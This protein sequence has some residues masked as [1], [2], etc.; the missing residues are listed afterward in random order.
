MEDILKIEERQYLFIYCY[1]FEDNRLFIHSRNPGR[2]PHGPQ[3][4]HVY[5]EL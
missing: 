1:Y 3:N 4:P 5:L 2:N